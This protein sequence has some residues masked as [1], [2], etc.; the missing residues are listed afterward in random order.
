MS[1]A[2]SNRLARIGRD[3][4]FL[5]TE[6]ER[7]EEKSSQDEMQPRRAIKKLYKPGSA[8]QEKQ[9]LQMKGKV[10]KSDGKKVG[11]KSKQSRNRELTSS[12][13][14]HSDLPSPEEPVLRCVHEA[15]RNLFDVGLEWRGRERW[16]FSDQPKRRNGKTRS[17]SRMLELTIL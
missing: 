3:P 8:N 6:L 15:H 4:A 10:R 7:R 17:R 2:D 11:K 5:Q 16:K 1:G 13:L 9:R 12:S 14:A